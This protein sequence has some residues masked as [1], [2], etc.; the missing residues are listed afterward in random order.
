[1]S[2]RRGPPQSIEELM[3]RW[4]VRI[5]RSHSEVPVDW[6]ILEKS[7][8]IYDLDRPVVGVKETPKEEYTRK[9][10]DEWGICPSVDEHG[11]RVKG[12][13][14]IAANTSV[15]SIAVDPQPKPSE[16]GT[17][18]IG[19]RGIHR[20]TPEGKIIELIYSKDDNPDKED[21]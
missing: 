14:D 20:V 21:D 13:V 2:E 6:L 12:K 16:A 17:Q 9:F 5:F 18:P 3:E 10:G 1:M 19:I 4:G 8:S 11:D 15:A 7:V